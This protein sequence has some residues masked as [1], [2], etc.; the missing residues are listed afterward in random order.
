VTAEASQALEVVQ[1]Q[2]ER[3]SDHGLSVS[4]TCTDAVQ[5]GPLDDVPKEL[6]FSGAPENANGQYQLML[7][8]VGGRPAY[9]RVTGAER[10]LWYRGGNWGVTSSV[11]QSCLVEPFLL[12]CA[13]GTHRS[14]H[15][16]ELRRPRWY[17]RRGRNREELDLGVRLSAT[18]EVSLAS[19]DQAASSSRV[20]DAT[21][22][23]TTDSK[24]TTSPL[25]ESVM[26]SSGSAPVQFPPKDEQPRPSN[27][28][29]HAHA[30]WVKNVSTDL[31]LADASGVSGSVLVAVTVLAEVPIKS[32]EICVD[33]AQAVLR[34]LCC[35]LDALEV[36]MPERVDSSQD[37][38]VKWSERKRRLTVRL[39]LCRV[40]AGTLTCERGFGD[41]LD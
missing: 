38:L 8:S 5:C 17:V 22:H 9:R 18:S 25:E 21:V 20:S 29:S 27:R 2:V 4:A 14:R 37:P 24:V 40:D 7:E 39:P 35:D 34:I 1:T 3:S 26:S 13:D 31:V 10:V 11:H 16:L 33:V 30:S 41:S 36:A 23:P 32:D 12:R 6:W 19:V 15:P 28:C